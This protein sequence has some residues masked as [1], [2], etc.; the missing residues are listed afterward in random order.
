MLSGSH[1]PRT[2]A[3]VACAGVVFALAGCGSSA[4]DGRK[5]GQPTWTDAPASVS[6]G[7]GQGATV[8]AHFADPD[9]DPVTASV[10]APADLEATLGTDQILLHANYAVSGPTSV[11]VTLSDG[12]SDPVAA[13]LAVDVKPLAWGASAAWTSAGPEAR[14]HGTFIVDD[15]GGRAVLVGGSGY[16][17]QLTPLDDVWEFAFATTSWTK[18]TPTGDLPSGGGSR[19]AAQ[20]PGTST[21]YLFGGY[22]A[23][24]ASNNELYRVDVDGGVA[25]TLVQQDNPPPARALHAFA[26]DAVG[27]RFV[28]FGGIDSQIFG[29]TWLMHLEGDRAVWTELDTPVA[30]S[31]RY[32][33]F[34]GFDTEARRLIV[35]SGAQGTTMLDP[36]R[37]V[38]ALDLA[39]EPPV[40]SKLLEGDADGVPPG[41]RNGCSVFDPS[42]PRLYVFG[43][44]GDGSTTEPGLFALD[45]R[46]GKEQ[47]VEL[48][49]A[50][51]PAV[52]SSGFGFYDATGD[53]TFF[54]FGNTTGGVFRDVTPLGY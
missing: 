22:G 35:Y 47:W 18:L 21:A 9:G 48:T 49:L 45:V 8:G 27:D 23:N 54:G 20:I 11:G 52:R 36:A 3:S 28:A 53:R 40:W 10:D 24:Q 13:S 33:F 44:T 6:I 34:Y 4:D 14:E 46:P 51:E 2:H 29:D 42:G 37:D 31:P 16:A 12:K 43:G 41:R 19:R 30:P 5:N 38:W 1:N 39:R 15:A 17:P 50:D 32:G 26:Y 7:Q 25:F